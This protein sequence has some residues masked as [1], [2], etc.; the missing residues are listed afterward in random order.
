[1]PKYQYT[2][3]A[4]TVFI[5]LAKDGHTWVASKYDTIEVDEPVSH[6]LLVPVLPTAA[7][8]STIIESPVTV[9]EPKEN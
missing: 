7:T 1:L 2:G 4:P 5:T 9:D 6:P 8:T 3:D